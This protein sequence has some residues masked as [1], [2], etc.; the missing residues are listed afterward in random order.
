MDK[1]RFLTIISNAKEAETRLCKLLDEVNSEFMLSI[2]MSRL[3]LAPPEQHIGDKLGKHP[4]HELINEGN[5]KSGYF[6]I[7]LR[8]PGS[9]VFLF[10]NIIKNNL[11]DLHITNGVEI[12]GMN[13]SPAQLILTKDGY[14]FCKRF[15]N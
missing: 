3:L 2:M 8:I 15:Y 1:D 9:M 12:G 4:K 5:K 14:E 7:S 6:V 10:R 11:I 13:V